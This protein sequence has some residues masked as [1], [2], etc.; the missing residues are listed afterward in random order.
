MSTHRP[1]TVVSQVDKIHCLKYDEIILLLVEKCPPNS[2]QLKGVCQ[3]CPEGT[4]QD[5]AGQTECRSCP[6]RPSVTSSDHYN[7]RC[8]PRTSRPLLPH[9]VGLAKLPNRK[10]SSWS[11]SSTKTRHANGKLGSVAAGHTLSADRKKPITDT[12]YKKMQ[13]QQSSMKSR[14]HYPHSYQLATGRA[15]DKLMTKSLSTNDTIDDD[16][17]FPNPCLAGGTCFRAVR[18]DNNKIISSFKCSCR[19]GTT[20]RV[21]SF[22][23]S[24]ILVIIF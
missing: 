9:I 14:R 5:R 22:V 11:P 17:C 1:T 13:F 21:I 16:P 2:F 3:P 10:S 8:R 24:A 6:I 7:S 19:I 23:K 15:T 18:Y 12:K 4:F 20:G